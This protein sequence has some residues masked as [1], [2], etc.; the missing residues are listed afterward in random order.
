MIPARSIHYGTG[1]F[2]V[3]EVGSEKSFARKRS[4]QGAGPGRVVCG[5]RRQP[6]DDTV[7]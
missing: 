2:E 1:A 7:S 3:F 6:D 5:S 4:R